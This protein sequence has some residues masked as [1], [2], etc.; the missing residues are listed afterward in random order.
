MSLGM[1]TTEVISELTDICICQAEIIKEQS[2]VLAQLGIL[3]DEENALREQ[4]RLRDIAGEWGED[5]VW[6]MDE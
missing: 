1:S 2:S 6:R 5:G 3:I 4:N